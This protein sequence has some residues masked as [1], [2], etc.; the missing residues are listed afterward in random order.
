[1]YKN[2][3]L[4]NAVTTIHHDTFL[5]GKPVDIKIKENPFLRERL[6][7]GRPSIKPERTTFM[8]LIK[9]IPRMKQPPQSVMNIQVRNL[10]KERPLVKERTSSVLRLG[11]PQK[12]MPIKT[13]KEP[14]VTGTRKYTG[15]ETFPQKQMQPSGKQ[16]QLEG[17]TTEKQ[18]KTKEEP[19]IEGL[20][21]KL[22]DSNIPRSTI[23]RSNKGLPKDEDIQGR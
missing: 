20:Q 7:I 1:M 16:Q 17:Y 21:G 13:L 9:E 14:T 8:P 5:K 2:A 18:R 3:F 4:S 6:S 22:P 10:K 23:Q 12:T 15:K 19:F 11:S